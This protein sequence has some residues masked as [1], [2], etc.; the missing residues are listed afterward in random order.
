MGHCLIKSSSYYEDKKAK[1]KLIKI[2]NVE[3]K[4][5]TINQIKYNL[6]SI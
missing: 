5:I 4:T 1:T 2:I 3:F 6:Y